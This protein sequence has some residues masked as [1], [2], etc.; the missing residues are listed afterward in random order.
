MHVITPSVSLSYYCFGQAA[1]RRQE[2]DTEGATQTNTNAWQARL[3]LGKMHL[4]KVP[5]SNFA[6]YIFP[7]APDWVLRINK[8]DGRPPLSRTRLRNPPRRSPTKPA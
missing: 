8:M 2:L 3:V 5:L 6:N 4:Q 7:V 1:R